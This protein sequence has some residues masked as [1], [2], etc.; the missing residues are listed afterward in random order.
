MIK[1]ESPQWSPYIAGSLTGVLIV[2]SALVTGNLFG[3]STTF[4]RGAGM[5]EKILSPERVASLDYFRWF[6]PEVDWQ[7]MFVVGVLFGSLV[8]ALTSNTFRWQS[9]P[10]MWRERFGQ[11]VTKRGIT[12]FAGGVVAMFG[13]RLAGG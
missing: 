9:L 3:A 6:V 13:A 2:L 11:S 12:A 1:N 5:L 8:S 4:V 10:N 7:F